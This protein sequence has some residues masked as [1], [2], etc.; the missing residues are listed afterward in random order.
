VSKGFQSIRTTI[1]QRACEAVK[2]GLSVRQA[3]LQ[4]NIPKST[5]SDLITGRVKMGAQ[6]GPPRYLTDCEEEE[7]S[8]FIT[9]CASIGCAKTKKD[10]ISIVEAVLMSKGKEVHISN[11]WWESFRRR[12]PNFTLRTAEKLTY[13]RLVVTDE[14]IMNKYFDLLERTLK[15]NGLIDSP[16]QIFNCD[17]TGLCLYHSPSSVVACK[18]QK[19]P[20]DV[21]TGNKTQITVLGCANAA[22][23]VLAP[24][25]IFGRKAL[26]QKLT[27][28]E[29]PGTMYGLSDKG[30]IDKLV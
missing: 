11:G 19:H 22:G 1:L 20:R 26:S 25:V 23:Y 2:C 14:I 28:G 10:V 16:A 12:H 29:V 13:A 7:L 8:S 24:L 27:V 30:W 6:S 5:L 4:Y 9:Q 17:E 15:D 21:T 3:A 18:G